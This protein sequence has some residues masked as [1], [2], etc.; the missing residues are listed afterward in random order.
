V[1]VTFSAPAPRWATTARTD[2]VTRPRA[3]EFEAFATAAG[4]RLGDAVGAWGLWNEPNHPRFL[5]PQVRGGRALSPG[6]YRGLHA[7]GVRG[8]AA[9]GQ[10][11]DAMLAGETAPGGDRRRS[12]TPL[13]FVRGVQ[14]RGCARL[15]IDAWAHHPYANRRGPF[16]VPADRD[17]VTI[18]VLARLHRQLDRSGLRRVPVWITEFGVQSTPDRTLGVPLARQAEYRSIAERI[19]ATDRRVAAFAQYLLADDRLTSG[20]QSG[21]LGVDGRRKPAYAEF[22]TPLVARRA[23]REA[24]LWGVVRPAAGATRVEVVSGG[25]VVAVRP[26]D[27]TGTWTARVPYKRGRSWSVRWTDGD[28]ATYAGPPTRSYGLPH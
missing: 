15:R 8:L 26:T 19:A 23:G 1:L 28:G 6:I 24:W 4:R 5:L 20:F 14:C 27:G 10:G 22:R 11:P 2:F 3:A 16:H 13:A 21:L 25:R 17:N 12:V 7:A 18:G 9:A